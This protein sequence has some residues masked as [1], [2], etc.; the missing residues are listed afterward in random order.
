MTLAS[1]IFCFDDAVISRS[2]HSSFA[3]SI[4]MQKTRAIV[5]K[6]KTNKFS[7]FFS[8]ST[9]SRPPESGPAVVG[10]LRPQVCL[11]WTGPTGEPQGRGIPP[12]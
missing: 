2:D 5:T 6:K 9:V 1:F 11:C 12:S 8:L 7:R 10:A 3:M 4:K